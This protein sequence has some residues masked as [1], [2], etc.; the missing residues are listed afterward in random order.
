MILGPYDWFEGLTADMCL[1]TLYISMV[2]S[3]YDNA[4]RLTGDCTCTPSTVPPITS[5]L[6]RTAVLRE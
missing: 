4:N 1:L 5:A 2:C 6:S 3:C